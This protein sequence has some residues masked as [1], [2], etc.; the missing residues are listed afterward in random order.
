MGSGMSRTG[1]ECSVS[2]V[3]GRGTGHH[4]SIKGGTSI[5]EIRDAHPAFGRQQ[6]AV[7]SEIRNSHSVRGTEKYNWSR[8]IAS[9]RRFVSIIGPAEKPSL[10]QSRNRHELWSD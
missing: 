5:E 1:R 6:C 3:Q 8:T 4:I 7:C 9:L 10:S 2:S